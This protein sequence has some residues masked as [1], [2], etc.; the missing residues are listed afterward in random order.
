MKYTEYL[1]FLEKID[2]SS[3]SERNEYV[4][5]EN[6][7]N[8]CNN[9]PFLKNYLSQLKGNT[10][11]I[12]YCQEMEWDV[13]PFEVT[14]TDNMDPTFLYYN[15]FM[16]WER[17]MFD[18]VGDTISIG[19]GFEPLELKEEWYYI[20]IKGEMDKI[21]LDDGK[22]II[23]TH[24]NEYYIVDPHNYNKELFTTYLN[25]FNEKGKYVGGPY[26]DEQLN[27]FYHNRP[28]NLPV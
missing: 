11:K 9:N 18:E 16:E 12:Y 27:N 3:M 14:W 6:I 4:K 24:S 13:D 1:K 22:Y 17:Y 15:N 8:L 7:I 23:G 2:T 21:T 10:Y 20:F 25:N 26:S 28:H 19:D 5:L